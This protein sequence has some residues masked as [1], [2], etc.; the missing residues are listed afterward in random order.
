MK[1]LLDH[2]RA[3]GVVFV[4]LLIL[5][6]WLV[7]AVF[8]QKFTAF[9]AVTLKTGT[10]GLNLPAKAD[11]KVRG[12]IV[13]Q[14]N[15]AESEGN[16]A[17][18]TLGI[19]PDKMKAIPANV[20]A[21]LVPKTLFGE[22][23]V[24][25]NIPSDPSPEPLKSGDRITQTKLPIEVERVLN[26]LY[27]LLRTVQPAELNYTL[28][29]L[30]TALEGRGDKVGESLVTLDGYLKRMNPQ[31]PALIDDIKL[32]ATVT[33][34]YAD[35]V[36][37]LAQT[38][39]NTVKTGNTLV[40]K[41][42]KLNAFLTDLASFSDT[43]RTFLDDNGN[44]IIRLGQLSEPIL[45][46]LE[47]Y[48][49]TFPCLLE[50]IV[51]QAPR[52]AQTFRGFVFHIN[53]KVLPTQPRGYTAADRQVYGANNGPNCAGLPSPAIPYYPAQGDFPNLNDGANGIGKGDNQR[54]ATGFGTRSQQGT[55]KGLTTGTSGTASQ[56]AL[57]NSLT[58]PF[59]GIPADEMSDLTSLLFAP[60]MAGTEVSVG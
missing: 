15:K 31:I 9:D 39:R 10:A 17:T 52:L 51:K 33:D 45:A 3:L 60:A 20:T 43:T 11:V 58:A 25:L 26:D 18:L 12:V 8:T 54:T 38:L 41:E 24:D 2:H 48:S 22:K 21:A 55:A 27:P 56:R 47:R 49:G 50:G 46:L 53:L 37:Q 23:Y 1:R 6:V 28:N 14:V 29:A 36:P 13:G 57:I 7:N 34:T 59:L 35:V 4:G 19:R 5:G 40:T 44:N 16:G 32:L 42:Q 30:A